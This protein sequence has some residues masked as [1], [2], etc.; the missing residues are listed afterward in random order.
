MRR[1]RG[2]TSRSR[3]T[4]PRR[5]SDTSRTVCPRVSSGTRWISET[6]SLY[7]TLFPFILRDILIVSTSPVIK[8]TSPYA[9]CMSLSPSKEMIKSVLYVCH[10]LHSLAPSIRYVTEREEPL[11]ANYMHAKLFTLCIFWN[12]SN[13]LCVIKLCLS[14][15]TFMTIMFPLT[16]IKICNTLF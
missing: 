5:R 14:I 15:Y 9:H 12:S 1:S 10:P 3:R 11:C 13:S 7:D 8:T 4:S 2:L 6:H 16:E